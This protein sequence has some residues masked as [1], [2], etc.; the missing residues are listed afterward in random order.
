[1]KYPAVPALAGGGGRSSHEERG[2][3]LYYLIFLF[4][5]PSRSSHEERGLKYTAGCTS[6]RPGCRSSH[7]ERGLKLHG[8]ITADTYDTAGRSSHEER[9][10]KSASRR[11]ASWSA[12]SL[13]A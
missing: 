12:W 5:P 1:M 11:R 7:E 10:L 6:R 4:Q 9:G 8:D 3:K 2:L 13:L